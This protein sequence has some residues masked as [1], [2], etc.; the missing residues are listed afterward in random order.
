MAQG[1]GDTGVDEGNFHV[2]QK[3][4][5]GQ[6]IVLLE[7]EAQ[8]LVPDGGQLPAA[9]PADIPAIQTVGALGGDV[10]TT[11]DVYTGGFA[12]A[13]LPHDGDEFTP[14]YLEG[15]VVGGFHEGIA[16]LVI[17]ADRVELNE[18]AHQKPPPSALLPPPGPPPP[19]IL[20]PGKPICSSLLDLEA[21]AE[22]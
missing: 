22:S 9:H 12:R 16:H 4:E 20:L 15:D 6:K 21:E 3:G 19:D 18:C 8:L 17:L 7:D 14:V 2:F 1:G 11:D 5:L 13:G 10:Q